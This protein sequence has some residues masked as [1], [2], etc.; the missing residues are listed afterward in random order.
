MSTIRIGVAQVPPTPDLERNRDTALGAMRQ[1]AGQGVELLCFPESHLPGYRFGILDTGAPCDGQGLAQATAQIAGLCRE[2]AMGVVLGTETPNPRGKP[3]NSALVL[4]Q[5]GAPIA[6][7]H[8]SRLT[9]K[10]ATAY[11]PGAGPTLFVFKGITMG[12]VI[13]FEGFRFPSTTRALARAGA[14]VVFHPQFNSIAPG[15]AWKQPVHE[16]LIVA[17]AAENT[18]Y[19]VSANMSHPRNNCRSLV[20]APDGLI[21]EASILGQEMILV[22]DLDP[23][24]ATHDFLQGEIRSR[25]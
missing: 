13:C 12:L 1:A 6:L 21:Q 5:E 7:H 18:I 10:E 9:P 22:A 14:Q 25:P 20:V 24:L 8:K 19:F 17:R 2:L 3:F 16:A 4:D 15:T 23:A 11:A